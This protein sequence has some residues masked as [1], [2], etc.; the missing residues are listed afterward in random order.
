MLSKDQN[1][2][3]VKEA[4]KGS[5][6]G[7]QSDLELDNSQDERI[8]EGNNVA[9]SHV[10]YFPIEP[11]VARSQNLFDLHVLILEIGPSING[12]VHS[13]FLFINIGKKL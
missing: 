9:H 2:L 3:S 5:E 13:P 1:E 11:L 6:E 10:F 4:G 8:T 7:F 12:S